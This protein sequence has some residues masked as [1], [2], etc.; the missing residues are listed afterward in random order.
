MTLGPLSAP[1]KTRLP[2]AFACL[3][4]AA[5]SGASAA[6]P[7]AGRTSKSSFT[8]AIAPMLPPAVTGVLYPPHPF[9]PVGFC[10]PV[11]K[12]GKTCTGYTFKLSAKGGSLPDGMGIDA[13]SGAVVGL[14]RAHTDTYLQAGSKTPGLYKFSVCA[15]SKTGTRCEPTEIAVFTLLGGTWKGTFQGDPGAFVCNTPLAGNITLSLTQKLTIAKGVP[16]STVGGTVTLDSLPPLSTAAGWDGT[17]SGPCTMTVQ[18]FGFGPGK[19]ASP[20]AGGQNSANGVWNMGIAPDGSLG[21]SL[22]LQDGGKGGFF[23]QIN[24]TA[25]R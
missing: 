14:P 16:I 17:Q 15:V 1:C 25:T 8:V 22:T 6:S 21:G 13:Q 3:C 12:F 20:N 2:A 10:R 9:G 5:L 24:F 18:K 4:L 7:A 23:S 11:V 19:I